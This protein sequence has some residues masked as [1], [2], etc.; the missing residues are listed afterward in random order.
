MV[1]NLQNSEREIKPIIKI[2]NLNYNDLIIFLIPFLIFLFY[3][4]IYN[5]GVMTIDSYA[6]LHQIATGEFSNWHPF[7]HTFIEMICVSIYPSPISIALFQVTIFS[8]IWMIICKYF[9][10]EN[11]GNLSKLFI[12]QVIF[13]LIISLIP[14]NPFYSITLWKDI[15]F[16]YC[17]L[18]LCFLIKVMLDRECYLD[19]KFVILLSLTMAF[20]ARLRH[21]GFFVILAFLFVLAIYLFIKNKKQN[22][23][24][25]IPALT[26]MFI[27]LFG[28]LNIVYDVAE[29]PHDT[30]FA[31][32]SHL[33]ADYDLNLNLSDTD[34]NQIHKLLPEDKIREKYDVYLID[35]ISFSVDR[36]PYEKNKMSYLLMAVDYSIKNPVHF[37]Q[38]LFESSSM[39]WDVTRDGDWQGKPYYDVS[40]SSATKYFKKYNL[41]PVASFENESSI[42]FGTDS[43][44]QLDSFV[45]FAR[46]N[47]YMDTLFNSPALYM[48]LAFILLAA[49]N[50]IT[51]S[52]E[53]YLVY[54]PNMINIIVVFLSTPVQDN[55][56]L[57][58]NLL[59]FYMLV[60]ILMGLLL[61]V[62]KDGQNIS[63]SLK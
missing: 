53:I 44:N 42:N 63:L 38:Y 22:V 40:G 41:T 36:T 55:R 13:T 27:L 48:Y 11:E 16:S 26:I 43:F 46:D 30:L 4:Y 21:N 17:M 29:N 8:L 28:S 45:K 6:Q 56:Y 12:L 54:L 18:F 39:V 62:K 49:I 1:I 37:I 24:I 9:R 35:T 10:D 5:P 15:L 58:P 57:Y 50:I 19:W 14:I 51:K 52:K 34:R 61:I 7:F 23:Y 33:L 25:L 3:L 2:R 47:I 31:K 32:T 60:I 20:V 59:I